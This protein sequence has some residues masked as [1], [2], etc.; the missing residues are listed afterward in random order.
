MSHNDVILQTLLF[1][2]WHGLLE[3]KSRFMHDQDKLTRK[4]A[5]GGNGV[6]E[7]KRMIQRTS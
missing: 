2:F 3:S 1:G 5:V 4:H 6:A 7:R